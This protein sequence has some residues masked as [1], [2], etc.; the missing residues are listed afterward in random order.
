M[1]KIKNW[2]LQMNLVKKIIF[3]VIFFGF[4][5]FSF[6]KLFLNKNGKI[7]YQTEKVTKGNLIV[8]VSGSGTV[9]S[10]NSSNI[11]TEATG[12]VTNIYVKDGDIVKTGDKIAELELDLE[13]QQKSS[14][15]WASY[16]SAKNSLQ[17][18]KDNLYSVQADLFTKWQSYFNL[19][20]SSKYENGDKT[21]NTAERQS[22]TEYR[23]S[24]DNWLLSEAK[25][26]SQQKAIEQT[27]S[28]L[29]SAWYSYQQASPI[30]YAPISGTVSGLSLQIGSVINSQSSSNTSATTNKIANIK[31]DALPTLSIN[32]TEI[33]IP[34]IK[35]G[36]K[37]TI[38]FDA[39]SDKTFTG[40][41]ISI[42]TVGS[43][44]SGVTN[45]PTVILLDTKSNT[46]LPN[47]GVTAN[48]ITNTKDEVLL[49]PSSAV[50]SDENGNNYVQILKN[51]KPD[52]Q[53]IEIGL[54]SDSQTEIT[55]GLNVGDTVITSTTQTTS[56]STQQTQS[57]FGGFGG[58]GGGNNMRIQGR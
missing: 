28:S 35:I 1:L 54:V 33:D 21:P 38:T 51:G 15:A 39:F 13:G 22:Q 29:N 31:T 8:T 3:I 6:S 18:T 55:S 36:D 43:V 49:I 7:T 47:M 20:T 25:Y 27:Q 14:Q 41:V 56:P 58:R 19:A 24:E 53:N 4:G 42:D 9:A 2:F 34:K 5:Y 30:I 46:I 50:K 52:N 48:I 45:Y 16:Q 12:V 26:K 10:T 40:K 37:A 17:T 32:L 23:I 57:V 11:T 44:S